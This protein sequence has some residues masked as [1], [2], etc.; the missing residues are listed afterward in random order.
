MRTRVRPKT[1]PRPDSDPRFRKV[2]NDLK[3]GAARTRSHPPAA[4]KAREAGAAAKGPPKERLVA[5]ETKQVDKVEEA[6][7]KKP[8]SSSFLALLQSEI[9][10]VMPKTLGDT[11]KFMEGGSSGEMK[12]GLKGN[13]TKQKEAASG[14]VKS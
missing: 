10:K 1:V 14:G 9:A 8:E 12:G 13:V 5:G 4:K 11:E 6:P 3:H 7:T 2:M